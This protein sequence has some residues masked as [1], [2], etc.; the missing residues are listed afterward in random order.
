MSEEE[1]KEAEDDLRRF[2]KDLKALMVDGQKPK[3]DAQM[4]QYMRYV[5]L[6]SACE[7]S[8]LCLR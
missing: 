4:K 2:E 7:L 1:K 5:P 6:F 8:S 3:T